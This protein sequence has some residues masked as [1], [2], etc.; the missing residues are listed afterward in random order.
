MK[1]SLFHRPARLPAL[2]ML[3]AALAGGAGAAQGSIEAPAAPAAQ[4]RWE[5]TLAAF[6]ASDRDRL[7]EAD[8]VLFVG[9]STIRLWNKLNQDFRQVPVIINRGFGGSTMADC[10]YFS[11]QLVTRYRPKQVLIYAGDNDLAEGR[12][13]Q[14]VLDNFANFVHVVRSELPNTRIAYISIKPSPARA[15]LMPRV[16][17]AN[18]LLAAYVRTLDKAEYIDIFTPMLS[19]DGNPQP[20]LFRADQ[21]HLNDAGYSLWRSVI[22]GHLAVPPAAPV[23]VALTTPATA[24]VVSPPQQR[25]AAR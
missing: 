5:S 15:A 25:A 11:R 22:A 21:L 13:P 20:E 17:E 4:A 1:P 24:A 23:P 9:S 18:A 19:A 8:G 2:A 14:Q 3:L 6:A 10:D 7:P 16:R 12:T